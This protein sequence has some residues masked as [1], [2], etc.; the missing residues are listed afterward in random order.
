M[1]QTLE[2]V[3]LEFVLTLLFLGGFHKRSSL[4]GTGMLLLVLLL[5]SVLLLLASVFRFVWFLFPF[6]LSLQSKFAA[7]T[8]RGRNNLHRSVV[9]NY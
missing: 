9:R 3:L 2:P 5:Y 6:W 8:I 4:I 7:R 1:H